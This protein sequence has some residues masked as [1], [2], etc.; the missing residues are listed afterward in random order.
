M[1]NPYSEGALVERPAIALFGQL[2]WDTANCFDEV[3]GDD[4]STTTT[5][6]LVEGGCAKMQSPPRG[7][8]T[9]KDLCLH[10]ADESAHSIPGSVNLGKCGGLNQP[11]T[12]L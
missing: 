11:Q 8:E 1:N 5:R 12:R 4:G 3:F 6:Q 10:L 2:D 7:C 9:A